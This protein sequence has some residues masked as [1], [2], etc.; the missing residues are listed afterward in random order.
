MAES[1]SKNNSTKKTGQK[2]SQNKSSNSEKKPP[3]N[4]ELDQILQPLQPQN[5]ETALEEKLAE[6]EEKKIDLVEKFTSTGT[7]KTEISKSERKLLPLMRLLSNNPFQIKEKTKGEFKNT[8]LSTFIDEY[9][10]FGIPL[11][12]KGR[13]EEVEVIQSLF[14][15]D[16]EIEKGDGGIRDKLKNWG[17]K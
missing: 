2:Q 15:Q 16:V 14:N 1:K 13:K 5:N 4:N 6:L 8:D 12:R 7:Q 10:S 17:G 9:I 3:E 11:E